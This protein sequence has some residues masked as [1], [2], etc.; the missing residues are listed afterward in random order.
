MR[1][2]QDHI[3]GCGWKGE[4]RNGFPKPGSLWCQL[5]ICKRLEPAIFKEQPSKVK[6]LHSLHTFSIASCNLPAF[7]VQGFEWDWHEML[8]AFPTKT[9]QD[10]QQDPPRPTKIQI[11]FKSSTRWCKLHILLDLKFTMHAYSPGAPQR[12]QRRPTNKVAQQAKVPQRRAPAHHDQCLSCVI[13]RTSPHPHF[14]N[15]PHIWFHF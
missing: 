4:N 11:V 8:Q 10:Q 2:R 12:S 14:E 7:C 6:I 3:G 5:R 9:S 1:V 15:G 13:M